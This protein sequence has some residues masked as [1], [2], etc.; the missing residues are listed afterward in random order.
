[1]KSSGRK[2]AFRRPRN[3]DGN[4]TTQRS[5]HREAE[6]GLARMD[7]RPPLRNTNCHVH[8]LQR[9]LNRPIEGASSTWLHRAKLYPIMHSERLAEPSSTPPIP[10][11]P[12]IPVLTCQ[13][14]HLYRRLCPPPRLTPIECRPHGQCRYSYSGREK[15][16]EVDA[17][18]RL[19]L[20]ARL[21]IQNFNCCC[22]HQSCEE[23]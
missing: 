19:L 18:N 22:Y 21:C 17:V 12:L 20:A 8:L 23:W 1:M 10:L 9:M 4:Q 16:K 3:I 11:L 5:V 15:A 7:T 2:P 6:G 13:M 14:A